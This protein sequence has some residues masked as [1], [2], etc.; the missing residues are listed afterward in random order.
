MASARRALSIGVIIDVIAVVD[1][2]NLN[3]YR[4]L[5]RIIIPA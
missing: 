4:I 2:L 1:F 3:V 5:R